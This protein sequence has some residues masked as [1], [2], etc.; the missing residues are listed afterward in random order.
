MISPKRPPEWTVLLAILAVALALR[1]YGMNWGL[2]YVYEEATPF[3]QA[4]TMWGWGG[5]V[6][7]DLNPHFF[8]YPSLTI[9]LQFAAQGLLYLVMKLGGGVSSAVDFHARYIADPTPYIIVGRMISVLFGVGTVWIAYLSGRRLG[10]KWAARLAAALLA[11]NVFH[12]ARSHLI[13]VDLPLTFFAL[14]ALWLLLGLTKK[15]SLGMYIAVGAAIGLAASTK[16]TGA[17]LLIPLAVAHFSIPSGA[18]ASSKTRPARSKTRGRPAWWVPLVSVLVAAGVFALTSPYVL[19]D[20]RTFLENFATERQHMSVGHFGLGGT[21]SWA[22][23]GRALAGSVL[24]WPCAILSLAALVFL[25][26][27]KRNRS[28]W[29]LGAFVVPYLLAVSTWS[30]HADRYLLPVVPV[31]L[32]L[33][34][35]LVTDS[36]VTALGKGR[37]RRAR[38]G[39]AAVAVLLLAAPMV[40]AYPSYLRGIQSDS[41]TSAARWIEQHIPGGSYFV[42]EPYGPEIYGPQ[43]ISQVSPEIRQ[44]V[45]DL[46]KGTPNYALL[47]VPM[48]QVVPERSEVFYDLLLYENADYIVTTGAVRSRYEK[49]PSRFR[50]QVAFYDSLETVYDRIAEFAP[51]GGGGSLITIYKNRQ[52]DLPFSKRKAVAGPRRLRPE[53]PTPTGSEEFFYYNLGLNY[54]VF[55]YLDGAIAAYDLAFLY[56]IERP[57]SFKNLV[58]RKAHC[59]LRMQRADEA[60]A[61]LGSMIE[62]A[63]TPLVREQ[64]RTLRD[65]IR[66]S[67][68]QNSR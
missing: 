45:L 17:I 19:L 13:E 4:W 59:L 5:P 34:A 48:F 30:M 32:V 39:I 44:E 1:L 37:P 29:V 36:R 3:K 50:R 54:E 9:Y 12:I 15:P 10:G 6:G 8:N 40:S 53:G 21:A 60:K 61:Y 55:L 41:R 49:E 16:Y 64:L 46:K 58:L 68:G 42:M 67:G 23:Y 35:A 7:V 57:S 22:F 66:P 38:T 26:G 62:K 63:P 33:A 28:V 2:P 14:L 11:V 47:V 43:M 18:R 51:N 56:P 27:K 24:G 52:H 25:G 65:A 20:S 31:L